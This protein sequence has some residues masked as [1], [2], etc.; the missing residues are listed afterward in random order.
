MCRVPW[1][2]DSRRFPGLRSEIADVLAP[3]PRLAQ[4]LQ[5]RLTEAGAAPNAPVVLA[6]A[7]ARGEVAAAQTA[8]VA[9]ELSEL[10]GGEVVVAAPADVTDALE[11]LGEGSVV[12]P[13]LL[14]PGVI[15]DRITDAARSAGAIAA[16]PLG[17]APELVEIVVDRFVAA[18]ARLERDVA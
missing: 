13:Y 17:H 16:A 6:T 18:Q 5:R 3:D 11:A 8:T 15:A 9:A 2:R 12:A 1:R 4:A 10:R 7:G 14:A